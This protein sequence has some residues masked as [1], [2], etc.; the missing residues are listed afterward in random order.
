MADAL[1]DTDVF[2]NYWRGD[3][4]AGN[5]IKDVLN[6]KITASFSPISAVELWQYSAL[7]RR[8]EIEYLAITSYMEEA[9]LYSAIGIKSGQAIRGF[10]RN[11]RR[12][13]LADALI[14]LTAS[15]RKEKVYSRNFKDLRLFYSN[16]MHY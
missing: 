13:L 2:I 14:A 12:R 1:F 5:L 10:S 9:P 11:R 3:T 7:T 8:E 4:G 16:V 6:N 15:D